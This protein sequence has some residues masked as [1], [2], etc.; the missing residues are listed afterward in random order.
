[1]TAYEA[2]KLTVAAKAKKSIERIFPLIKK[3]AANGEGYIQ[4]SMSDY[5]QEEINILE[6]DY[7]YQ[8]TAIYDDSGDYHRS[9][10]KI[11]YYVSWE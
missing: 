3:A 1:M 10:K 2:K 4:I 6:N 7:G 9:D 8:L 11:G 5:T